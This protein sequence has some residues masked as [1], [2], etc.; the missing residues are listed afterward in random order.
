MSGAELMILY[1]EGDVEA[2]N[3]LYEKYRSMVYGYLLKKIHNRAEVDDI[4]Q[5]VF[6]KLHQSRS[7]YNSQFPF[8]PWLFAVL[9]NSMN[10]HFRKQKKEFQDVALD[11]LEKTPPALQVEDKHNLDGL[12]PTNIDLSEDM[13]KAIELRFGSDFSFDEIAATLGTT[14]SNAR[15]LVSRALKKL[16]DIVKPSD[17]L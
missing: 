9:R 5:T 3:G 4:F 12:L 17:I 16:R 2:F 1:Q 13:R 10:D 15:Q 14:G 8:E 6:L 11:N 7:K